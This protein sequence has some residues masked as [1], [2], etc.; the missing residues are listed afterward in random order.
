[1]L[2]ILREVGCAWRKGYPEGKRPLP[3]VTHTFASGS[4][5]SACPG[6]SPPAIQSERRHPQDGNHARSYCGGGLADCPQVPIG[7][8]KGMI[9]KGE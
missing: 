1:M 6:K 8:G 9:E 7:E 4:N 3:Q 5:I 2:Q